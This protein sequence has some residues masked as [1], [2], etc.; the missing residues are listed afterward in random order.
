MHVQEDLPSY[1]LSKDDMEHTSKPHL[2]RTYQGLS[3]FILLC[4][5]YYWIGSDIGDITISSTMSHSSGITVQ[6]FSSLDMLLVV[7]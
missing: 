4:I 7:I 6:L 5:T 1:L 3:T 2:E